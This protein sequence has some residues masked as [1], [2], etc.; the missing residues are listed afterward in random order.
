MYKTASRFS[1][2]R[3]EGNRRK[4]I[5]PEDSPVARF[6]RQLRLAPAPV[7]LGY[8]RCSICQGHVKV[9]SLDKHLQ[10]IHSTGRKTGHK[11][12]LSNSTRMERAVRL[13]NQSSVKSHLLSEK[14]FAGTRVNIFHTRSTKDRAMKAVHEL[15]SYGAHVNL[16]KTTVPA[17]QDLARRIYYFSQAN[18]NESVASRMALAL[19]RIERLRIATFDLVERPP[20]D[21]S[22]WFVK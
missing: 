5:R 14:Q 12:K 20:V 15:A 10:K 22:I 1:R 8:T 13:P 19:K 6:Y 21:Y 18:G 16:I 7:P 11:T 17:K 3:R 9:Q 2:R 4:Y